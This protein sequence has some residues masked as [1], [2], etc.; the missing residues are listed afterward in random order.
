MIFSTKYPGFFTA[1]FAYFLTQY[2]DIYRFNFTHIIT[3]LREEYPFIWGIF[4]VFGIA[5]NC[6][7][8]ERGKSLYWENVCT[9]VSVP[10]KKHTNYDPKPLTVWN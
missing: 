2:L 8:L 1:I 6:G 9:T 7:R 4:L 5:Y 3:V 10:E